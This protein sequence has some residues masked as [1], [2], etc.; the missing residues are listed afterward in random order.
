MKPYVAAIL[1]IVLYVAEIFW[2]SDILGANLGLAGTEVPFVS[3]AMYIMY[4]GAVPLLIY[5][6]NYLIHSGETGY[7]NGLFP[8]KNKRY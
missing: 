4:G 5:V 8:R 6:G 2:L 7:E 3:V 1:L